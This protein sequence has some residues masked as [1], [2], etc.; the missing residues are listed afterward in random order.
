MTEQ[1]GEVLS[2][3]IKIKEETRLSGRLLSFLNAKLQAD[4]VHF[5]SGHCVVSKSKTNSY[6][7]VEI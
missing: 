4:G 1:K 6:K 7:L 5:D 3:K 2:V